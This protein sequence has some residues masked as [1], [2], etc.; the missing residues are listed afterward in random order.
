M[1]PFQKIDEL[2]AKTEGA[3]IALLLTTMITL[4]FGQVIL[5]N[6]FHEG[7]L[8]ADIFLRQLVVW[9][10][11]LGASL[12][13]RERKHIAI[14]ILPNFLPQHWK[15]GLRILADL[16]TGLISGL[17]AMAAWQF[18]Q[19]EAE[20]GSTLFLDLPVWIFQTVLPFSFGMITLRVF[21]RIFNDIWVS[22]IPGP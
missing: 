18:V 15:N 22:R 5:R 1:G 3:L 19:L 17:L 11:F 16:A 10:G 20:S 8:W 14:K 13:V 4:S 21:F 7:I 9:V 12:A 6:L 2:L